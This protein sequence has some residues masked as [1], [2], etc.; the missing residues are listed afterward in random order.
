MYSNE[1]LKIR[2]SDKNRLKE[3]NI[4]ANINRVYSCKLLFTFTMLPI[5][6]STLPK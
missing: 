4:N 5:F 6:P 3:I 2:I 1:N